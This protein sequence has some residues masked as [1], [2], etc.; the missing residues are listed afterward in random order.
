MVILTCEVIE[1]FC[2]IT[3]K[4]I[5]KS[6]RPIKSYINNQ[7]KLY[8]HFL[9]PNINFFP[10]LFCWHDLK[11]IIYITVDLREAYCDLIKTG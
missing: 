5:S 6:L 11:S 4:I 8:F 7:V 3:A 1:V 9:V 10:E 2:V